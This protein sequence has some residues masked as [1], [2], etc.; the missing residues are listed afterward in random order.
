MEPDSGTTNIRNLKSRHWTRWLGI[1]YRCVVPFHSF[2]E[3]NK[4]K[5][6]TSGLRSTR[7]ARSS[8]SPGSG[9][10]G[11]RSGRSRKARP[12][13]ISMRF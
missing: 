3:F 1:E 7:A 5:A 11:R 8:A 2:S 10:T 6:E 9:P 4:A 12:P 13:M